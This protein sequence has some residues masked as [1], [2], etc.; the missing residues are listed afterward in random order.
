ML[1]ED[2]LTPHRVEA[3]AAATVHQDMKAA[4]A[5]AVAVVAAARAAATAEKRPEINY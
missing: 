5:A 3:T 2:I 1:G 4:A